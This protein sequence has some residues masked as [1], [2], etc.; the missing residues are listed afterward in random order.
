MFR[1]ARRRSTASPE[2]PS[3]GGGKDPPPSSLSTVAGE[4]RRRRARPAFERPRER[5]RICE[6]E[7]EGDLL[8]K[9]ERT[10]GKGLPRRSIVVGTFTSQGR[11]FARCPKGFAER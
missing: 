11:R 3:D 10:R 7:Q 1:W 2:H 5:R 8:Q 6:A 9:L 4:A